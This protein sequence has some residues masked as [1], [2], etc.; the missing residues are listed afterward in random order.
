MREVLLSHAS[1]LLQEGIL[2]GNSCSEGCPALAV[3]SYCSELW[4]LGIAKEA[5][6]FQDIILQACHLSLAIT[7]LKT[8]VG[9]KTVRVLLVTADEGPKSETPFM[10]PEHRHHPHG[11]CLSAIVLLLCSHSD[12]VVPPWPLQAT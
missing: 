12:H 1:W 2:W 8:M 5:S 6:R 11:F 9:C 7:T 3:L 4:H 10:I